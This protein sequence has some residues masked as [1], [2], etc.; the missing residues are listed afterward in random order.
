VTL[1][2]STSDPHHAFTL[3]MSNIRARAARFCRAF[4]AALRNFLQLSRLWHVDFRAGPRG[5]GTTA[6]KMRRRVQSGCRTSF[7]QSRDSRNKIRQAI[8]QPTCFSLAVGRQTRQL[9]HCASD[10][11]IDAPTKFLS[12]RAEEP[13]ETRSPRARRDNF[14]TRR[15]RPLSAVA[16]RRNLRTLRRRPRGRTPRAQEH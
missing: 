6:R 5:K 12:T 14:E 15:L 7:Q 13:T 2:R 9:K 3:L 1:L 4:A 8:E 11:M 10:G 16:A